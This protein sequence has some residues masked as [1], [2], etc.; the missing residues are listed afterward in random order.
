MPVTNVEQHTSAVRLA[1]DLFVR[2]MVD[3]PDQVAV[4]SSRDSSGAIVLSVRVAPGDTG[5]LIGKG[6]RTVRSIRGLLAAV[7][8]GSRLRY[9]LEVE[10][11]DCPDSE[12]LKCFR[13]R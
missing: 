10:R 1:L 4:T 13:S 2:A 12:A 7:G 9:V 3:R 11:D 8:R 6:G 5:L